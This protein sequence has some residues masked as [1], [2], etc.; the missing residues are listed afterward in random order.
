[1]IHLSNKLLLQ[2]YCNIIILYKQTGNVHERFH[3]LYIR[4]QQ[5]VDYVIIYGI[6]KED[7][8]KNHSLIGIYV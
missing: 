3:G 1:M 7:L 5:Y 6:V 8:D 2:A 4:T